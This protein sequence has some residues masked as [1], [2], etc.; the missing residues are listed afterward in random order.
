MEANG[1]IGLCSRCILKN[2]LTVFEFVEVRRPG[3]Y[4]KR[5]SIRTLVVAY[6]SFEEVFSLIGVIRLC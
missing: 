5:T 3:S 1:I 4:L 2:A 6:M